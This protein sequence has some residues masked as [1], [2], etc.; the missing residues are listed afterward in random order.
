MSSSCGSG[1]WCAFGFFCA[2]AV[3]MNYYLQFCVLKFL[4]DVRAPRRNARQEVNITMLIFR[5]GC[6]ERS[7][8]YTR[9]YGEGKLH[10]FVAKGVSLDI[11]FCI[12][13]RCVGTAFSSKPDIYETA[14]GKVQH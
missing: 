9:Y 6:C 10:Q 14:D 5:R 11:I 8:I 3:L 2:V 13:V 1:E 4:N 12:W 7:K